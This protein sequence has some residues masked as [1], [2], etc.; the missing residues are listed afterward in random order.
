MCVYIFTA[1]SDGKE[2]WGLYSEVDLPEKTQL[3]CIPRTL[4]LHPE[5]CHQELSPYFCD[6][7]FGALP[8]RDWLLLY[9]VA[10]CALPQLP[11]AKHAPYVQ[12]FPYT[13]NTP[14]TYSNAEISLLEGT[15]LW[16][17]ALAW[18]QTSAEAATRVATWLASI[19]SE[20]SEIGSRLVEISCNQHA[21]TALWFWAENAYARC[22]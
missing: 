3:L 6:T 10:N 16:N 7:P 19:T 1:H 13:F 22:A 21:W 4:I 18:R 5:T 20:V 8:S 11:F 12:T 15:S 17:G 2:G 14:L 9:L